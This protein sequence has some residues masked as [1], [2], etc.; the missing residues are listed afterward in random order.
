MIGIILAAGMGSRCSELTKDT[1]KAL[2]NFY[3]KPNIENNIDFLI[4]NGCSKI[5]IVTGY[6]AEKFEYLK[7]IYNNIKIIYNEKYQQYNNI[8]SMN[9]VIDYIEEDVIILEGDIVIHKKFTLPINDKD[10]LYV[11]KKRE[12]DSKEWVPNIENNRIKKIEVKFTQ[13]E[14]YIG[15]MYLNK[16]DSV[17]IKKEFKNYFVEDF[18][19]LQNYWDD[20]YMNNLD[21]INLTPYYIN[22]DS[23]TEIDTIDDYILAKNKTNKLI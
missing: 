22:K 21:K 18:K 17:T 23:I 12:R 1:S 11:I 15:I 5:Y 14:S 2:F 4:E 3:G 7:Q 16:K 20:V 9:L 8:Y 19:F 13:A 6:M 10:S